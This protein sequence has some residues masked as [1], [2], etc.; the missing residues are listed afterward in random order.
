[1]RILATKYSQRMMCGEDL[2]QFLEFPGLIWDALGGA[3]ISIKQVGTEPEKNVF[4][5]IIIN[6][7]P[8]HTLPSP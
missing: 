7:F 6:S 4:V 5:N 8:G 2:K 1:M 3:V